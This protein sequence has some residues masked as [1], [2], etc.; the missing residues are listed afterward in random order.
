[1]YVRMPKSRCLGPGPTFRCW[2]GAAVSHVSIPHSTSHQQPVLPAIST[3]PSCALIWPSLPTRR[4]KISLVSSPPATY[5][6]Y[7]PRSYR[8]PRLSGALPRKLVDGGWR[9]DACIFGLLLLKRRTGSIFFP[10]Q[11][12]HVPT[13]NTGHPYT[14]SVLWNVAPEFHRTV[15]PKN[16][17]VRV[18]PPANNHLPERRQRQTPATPWPPPPVGPRGPERHRMPASARASRTTEH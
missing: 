18:L 15:Q 2:Q 11:R 5:I 14:S 8:Q 10:P 17:S 13:S 4:P 7:A 16:T 6:P 9:S 12:T 1:M 3:P